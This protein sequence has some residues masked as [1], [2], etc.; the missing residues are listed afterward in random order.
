MAQEAFSF[1]AT[2]SRVGSRIVGDRTAK[3]Q[4]VKGI[5]PFTAN[6]HAILPGPSR[7]E[8]FSQRR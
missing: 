7:I 3:S 2:Q 8:I 6:F 1:D 5:M 4:P